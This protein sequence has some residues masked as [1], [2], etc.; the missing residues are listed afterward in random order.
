MDRLEI[1]LRLKQ[2]DLYESQIAQVQA[3]IQERAGQHPRVP[4]VRTMAKVG[5]YTALGLLAHVGPIERFPNAGSRRAAGTPEGRI[6]RG[7]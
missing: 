1:D 3:R 6:V 2:H 5:E 4:L 7:A